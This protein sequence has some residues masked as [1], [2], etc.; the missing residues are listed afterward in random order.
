MSNDSRQE[1]DL[2]NTDHLMSIDRIPGENRQVFLDGRWRTLTYIG[3]I[4]GI[5]FRLVQD[6]EQSFS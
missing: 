3:R 5:K 4:D 1:T 6:Y 2:N